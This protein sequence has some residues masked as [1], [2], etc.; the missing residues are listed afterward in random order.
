M[1]GSDGGR[2]TRS[3]SRACPWWK[4]PGRS[5]SLGPMDARYGLAGSAGQLRPLKLVKGTV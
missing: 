4:A 2:G 5:E 3:G 1:L